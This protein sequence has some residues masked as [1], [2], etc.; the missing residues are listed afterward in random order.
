MDCVTRPRSVF[1]RPWIGSI[2]LAVVVAIYLLFATNQAF[3][4]MA[5]KIGQDSPYALAAGAVA[6]S[7]LYVAFCISLSVKYAIR[8]LFVM[9]VFIAAGA[10]WF[11]DS[12]GT[13]IGVDMVDSAFD[14]SSAEAGN[15]LTRSFVLH[16]LI[17]AG[18]PTFLLLWVRIDHRRFG[19]KLLHNSLVI[20]VCLAVAAGAVFSQSGT[21]FWAI[22]QHRE[23]T[24][25]LNPVVPIASVVKFA[26]RSGNDRKLVVQ[27]L[28]MD[29]H[30]AQIPSRKPRVLVVVVGET[31]RAE[32][33]S[34]GG[35][36]RP[37]NTELQRKNVTYF[38]DTSSCGTITAVSV[39]CMFSV[40]PRSEYSHDKAVRTEN[41]TDVLGH[42]GID[43][44]WW[45]NDLG[46]KSVADRLKGYRQYYTSDDADFC[47][48]GEC[49]D[50]IL[51]RDLD[52]WLDGVSQ[53]SLLV[54]H[55]EGSH[56]P[57]YHDRYPEAFRRFAPDC[58]TAEFSECT[59]EEIVNAYDNTIVYTDH[60]VASA[61][62]A[63]ERHDGTVDPS[64]IFV[65]DHGESLGEYG[66]Y[67]HG[68]P[69]F[70]APSQQIHIP[71]LVWLGQSARSGIDGDCLA[72]AASEPQS[73]DNLF[74]TVL[75]MMDV[76]TAVYD[77]AL[78]SLRKCRVASDAAFSPLAY[79]PEGD[80]NAGSTR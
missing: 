10:A 73:H 66:L 33:F 20:S 27:P 14:T 60:I 26:L 23:M 41:L 35:Y 12:F 78:D 48:G 46:S 47:K 16:M 3:W 29:A 45:D 72:A 70:M 31:A 50:A 43:V 54:L 49:I 53:D 7:A 52:G 56:G 32:N 19:A 5:Q 44:A 42:A 21:L 39:P 69:Y 40:Y 17:Y 74:H 30:V 59:H 68:A 37:T 65:S 11:M 55:I 62:S 64:L 8:P 67:L 4:A 1:R 61:I 38:S 22:R 76:S 2:A 6:L 71:Y 58:R 9:L 80:P 79:I 13:V 15:L 51:L 28:G 63:L 18:I 57:S 34:L 36:G 75:G 25:L 77:P 24:G